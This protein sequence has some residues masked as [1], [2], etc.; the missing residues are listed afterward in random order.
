[1]K[2]LKQSLRVF[3]SV[4]HN[5][6]PPFSPPDPCISDLISSFLPQT[7]STPPATVAPRLFLEHVR[8]PLASWPLGCSMEFSSFTQSLG[9]VP[10]LLQILTQVRSPLSGA[11]PYYFSI[12]TTPIPL[13]ALYPLFPHSFF[14]IAFIA[15][16]NT[17]YF[18][19]VFIIHHPNQNVSYTRKE[20]FMSFNTASPAPRF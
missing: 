4:F 1:M 15:F 17:I 8:Y 5:N 19:C 16:T 11:V 14:I 3:Y 18:T 9:S 2:F 13:L 20:V 6:L 10:Y 7:L 12:T